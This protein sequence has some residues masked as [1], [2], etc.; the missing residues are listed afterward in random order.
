M[1]K[2]NATIF[3]AL[4]AFLIPVSVIT[5]YYVTHKPFDPS[6]ALAFSLNL[7]RILLAG[8]ILALAGGIGNRLLPALPFHPLAALAVQAILGLGLIALLILLI[9]SLLA[10]H[11][12]LF[13]VLLL[14]GIFLLRHSIR[15][16]LEH[17]KTWKEIIQNSSTSERWI[18]ILILLALSS[19]LWTALAPPIKYD[20]LVYHLTL[21]QAY[22]SAGRITHLPWLMM[23]G[24]PQNAEMLYLLAMSLEAHPLPPFWA[25]HLPC[26]GCPVYL[27]GW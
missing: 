5:F 19:P 12:G 27:A 17:W 7:W 14:V 15:L 2:R 9:G 24:Y 11:T 25:G 18:G 16:W 21:P 20:A 6:F 4:A 22:L 8:S 10:V 26:W 1:M 3:T 23:S 13:A